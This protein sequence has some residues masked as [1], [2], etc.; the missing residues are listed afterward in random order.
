MY[1]FISSLVKLLNGDKQWMETDISNIPINQLYLTYSKVIV[2]LSNQFLPENVA[3]DLITLNPDREGLSLTVNELLLLNGNKTLQTLPYI[4]TFSTKFAKYADAFH[5]GYKVEPINSIA[6]F[7]SNLPAG[8]KTWL[9]LTKPKVDYDMFHKSCL[10]NVNGFFHL[11]D[12]DING[13]YVVDGMTSLHL[14]NHNQ[15]GVYSFKD[16]GQLTYIPITA[17]MVYKQRPEQL[18]KDSACINVGIDIS[19]KTVM[20]VLGGYLHVL[21]T[22]TF[23][24]INDKAIRIDMAN[25]PLLDR[26]YDSKDYIDLSSYN[27]STTSRNHNQISIQEFFSDEVLL[28]YL[29]LSQSFIVILDNPDIFVNRQAIHVTSLPDMFVGYTPPLYPVVVNNGKITNPWYTYEDGQYSITCRDTLK[30][31]YMYNTI[32]PTIVNSVD[33]ALESTKPFSMSKAYNLIIGSSTLV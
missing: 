7:S 1:V 22:K 31:N 25:L 13:A 8:D 4:P 28:K 16:I 29:T 5:A 2:I 14:S 26:Y 27:L 9:R 15:I 17:N 30:K 11:I 10:V 12:S 32:D 33:N 20:L 18:Y 3:V 23:T 19:N 21:D 6:S 24:A